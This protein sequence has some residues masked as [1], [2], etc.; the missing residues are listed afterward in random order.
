MNTDEPED[1]SANSAGKAPVYAGA[2]QRE[3]HRRDGAAGE[4]V[5]GVN[6]AA[7]TQRDDDD[8]HDVVD[9][10]RG[11]KEHAQFDRQVI[12]E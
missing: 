8:R 7:V 4:K 1:N 6:L 9:D 10:D 3:E 12:A 11:G 5:V 2:I